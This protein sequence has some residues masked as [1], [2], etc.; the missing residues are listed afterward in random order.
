MEIFEGGI[1]HRHGGIKVGDYLLTA[2]GLKLS[3]KTFNEAQLRLE[4]AMED[5]QVIDYHYRLYAFLIIGKFKEY[6]ELLI[7][8][9]SELDD[10]EM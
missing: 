8:R 4:K 10:E 5:E 7:A 3:G 2:N 6:I 9:S 1:I